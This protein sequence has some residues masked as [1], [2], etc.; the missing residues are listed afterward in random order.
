[1]G[2]NRSQLDDI[3]ISSG[4]DNQVSAYCHISSKELLATAE[5]TTRAILQGICNPREIEDRLHNIES[6]MADQLNVIKTMI[7]NIEDKLAQQDSQY[8]RANRKLHGAVAELSESVQSCTSLPNSAS[9]SIHVETS[10]ATPTSQLKQAPASSFYSSPITIGV[11]STGADPDEE[12]MLNPRQEEID[13]YNSSIHIEGG[14]RVF[15]YF[16]KVGDMEYKLKSWGPRRSLRSP[17]FYIFEYGYMMYIRL[18]PRQNGQNVYA[19]VGLTKGDYDEALE[20]PF[21]LKHRISILDQ[22]SSP[23]QDISSRVWDPKILCSGWN[24]KRPATGDNHECVGLGFPT[25][26]LRAQ[27]FLRDDNLLIKLT[28]YLD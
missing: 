27:H 3:K 11:R 7:L 20:W 8:R 14:K 4:G 16:W 28:V 2:Q 23:F 26:D 15:S 17:S 10:Q 12:D 13:R 9:N 25:E 18:F 21:I 5:L 6:Q 22:V 19:H 24:W 1:M